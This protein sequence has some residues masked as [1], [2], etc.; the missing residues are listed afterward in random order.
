ML[1]DEEMKEMQP[2]KYVRYLKN[3]DWDEISKMP[4]EAKIVWEVAIEELKENNDK[5]RYLQAHVR[6]L[7]TTVQRLKNALK[8]N[9]KGRQHG[10]VSS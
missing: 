5:I 7:G 9:K 4:E 6:Q 1:S 2:I 8:A 10:R 3:V